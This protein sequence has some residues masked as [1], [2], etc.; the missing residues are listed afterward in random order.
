MLR[1]LLISFVV[2]VAAFAAYVLFVPN[3]RETL[4]GIGIE[5]PFSAP[6]EVASGPGG[7]GGPGG[8]GGRRGGFGGGREMVVVTE[9]VVV[10]TINDSL[11]AIGDGSATRSVTVASPSSGTLVDILVKPGDAVAAGDLIGRLDAEAETIAR[12]R[13]RLALQNAEASLSRL[14]ELA[15]AANATTVQVDT[16]QLAASD[17]QLAYDNAELALSRRT[18][19]TPIAGTV[20]LIQVS[21]G[22]AVSAQTTVTTIEDISHI[23]VSFWVPERYATKVTTGMP[24]S[25]SAVAL[26]G[27]TLEGT[28]SAVDN[29]VD[30]ASRTLEVEADFAN[31]DGRLKPGM[32]FS[33][34]LAFSGEQ[35]PSVDPLSIQWSSDGAYLWRFTDGKVEQVP[36]KIIQR[37]SDGVMVDAD[38]AAGD[39]VVTQGVQQLSDGASVRLLDA[40]QGES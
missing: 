25:A 15:G 21:A 33:V 35:F 22:N 30:P 11:T 26:P 16:A 8:P 6:A 10:G 40:P 9:P 31:P 18:I 13:A 1:Q 24:V 37:N 20:G 7:R 39:E 27:E 12:D 17:A 2:I 34:A 14:R 38:L 28:V 4:A 29:R 5:L 23:T 32:S 3:A 36:V 19:T